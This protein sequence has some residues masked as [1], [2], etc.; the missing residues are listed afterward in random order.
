[1]LG[2]FSC[3]RMN[4][5]PIMLCPEG[6]TLYAKICFYLSAFIM[7]LH[8]SKSLTTDVVIQPLTCTDLRLMLD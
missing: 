1:M 3:C 6:I 4:L 8:K 2:L 5:L 7:P